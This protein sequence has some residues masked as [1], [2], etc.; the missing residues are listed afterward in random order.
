MR[1]LLIIVMLEWSQ[2]TL[3]CKKSELELSL[4]DLGISA[5]RVIN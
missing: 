1:T 4:A 3:C 2:V 5:T